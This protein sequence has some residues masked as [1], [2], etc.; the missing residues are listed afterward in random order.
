MQFKNI[1]EFIEGKYQDSSYVYQSFSLPWLFPEWWLPVKYAEAFL[2]KFY[3]NKCRFNTARWFRTH[4]W[5]DGETPL[6][7]MSPYIDQFFK[8]KGNPQAF[9]FWGIC[10]F[11]AIIALTIMICFLTCMCRCCCSKKQDPKVAPTKKPREK[12]E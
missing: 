11:L 4:N 7:E 12:I 9:I 6:Y 3:L 2:V 5:I 10:L 8:M 1:H